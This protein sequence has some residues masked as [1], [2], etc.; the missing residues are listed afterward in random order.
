[1][2]PPAS[3]AARLLQQ[4]DEALSRRRW[5]EAVTHLRN[6]CSL[7]PG[8]QAIAAR[9]REV[10]AKIHSDL[11]RAGIVDKAVAHLNVSFDEL[12][13]LDASPKAGF[14]LSRVNGSYDV[15]SILKISPM[16]P[17]EAKLVILELLEG[18]QI[19]LS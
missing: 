12:T 16:S 13:K 10:E 2:A 6:A 1:P 9:S 3:A 15:Q 8:N 14:I 19:R 17:L 7:E 11:R 5:F 18:G 4:A